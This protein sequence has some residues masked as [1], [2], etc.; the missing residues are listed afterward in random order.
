MTSINLTMNVVGNIAPRLILPASF[1]VEGDTANGW[2]ADWPDVLATDS[3]DAPDPIPTCAPAAGSTLPLGTTAVSCSVTDSGGLTATG[4]FNV[5]VVDTTDPALAGVPAD[6]EVITTDPTGTTLAYAAPTATDVVDP[7][8]DVTCTPASGSH[9]G[10]G[11]TTVTCTATDAS[12]NSVSESFD[13]SVTFRAPHSASAT[14]QDPIDVSENTFSTN[15]GRTLPIKVR[16]FVDGVEVKAG[17]ASLTVTPCSGGTGLGLPLTT[18]GGRWNASLDTSRLVGSC[19]TVTA[20]VQGLGA[21]GFRLELRGAEPAKANKAPA[22]P[23]SSTTRASSSD[24]KPGK[25]TEAK[26]AKPDTAKVDETRD[27]KADK[28]GGKK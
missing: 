3:E 23:T 28:A 1:S 14:W 8:P 5:T 13:M 4:G 7:S 21:G 20:W 16:L 6:S 17:S 19:H 25:A 15:H 24:T 18:G 12:G 10:I 9:V 22:T 26:T 27:Q 2:T 11:T